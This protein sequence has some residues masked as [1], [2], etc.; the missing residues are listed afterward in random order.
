MPE[1]CGCVQVRSYLVAKSQCP[2]ATGWWTVPTTE[3]DGGYYHPYNPSC[4][5]LFSSFQFFL[6][7][8]FYSV[9]SKNIMLKCFCWCLSQSWSLVCTMKLRTVKFLQTSP[10]LQRSNPYQWTFSGGIFL[11]EAH[12][13]CKMGS[14]WPSTRLTHLSF[15]LAS[16]MFFNDFFLRKNLLSLQICSSWVNLVK[17]EMNMTETTPK[18]NRICAYMFY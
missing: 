5:D 2:K 14:L 16:L 1:H 3:Q 17:T 7:Q 12:K 6:W 9:K 10:N 18:W 15:F 13:R 8:K 4:L 11:V